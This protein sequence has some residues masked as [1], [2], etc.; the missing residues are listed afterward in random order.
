MGVGEM[1]SWRI[2]VSFPVLSAANEIVW[3]VAGWW[4]TM[5]YIC[6]RVSWTR[7]GRPH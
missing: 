6:A 7:T 4:P 5:E 3:I 1:L 2:A